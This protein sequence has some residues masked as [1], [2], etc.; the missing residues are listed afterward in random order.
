MNIK[1]SH[2]IAIFAQYFYNTYISKVIRTSFEIR[3]AFSDFV[4]AKRN[5]RNLNYL[6]YFEFFDRFTIKVLN[7]E[8]QTKFFRR[9]EN[10]NFLN[11]RF[12]FFIL[13]LHVTIS[14]FSCAISDLIL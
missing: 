9:F 10:F 13:H 11:F 12:L 4:F 1:S 2:S 6:N 14:S 8:I 7:R 5:D 3:N